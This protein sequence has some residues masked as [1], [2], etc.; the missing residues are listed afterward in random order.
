MFKIPENWKSNDICTIK[1]FTITNHDKLS[2]PTVL[3]RHNDDVYRLSEKIFKKINNQEKVYLLC[4]TFELIDYLNSLTFPGL[5][6]H[7]LIS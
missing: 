6:V 2:N 1:C 4:K 5:P 3:S 7:K